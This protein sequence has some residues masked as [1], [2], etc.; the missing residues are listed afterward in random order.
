ME[1]LGGAGGVVGIFEGVAEGFLEAAAVALAEAVD[2]DLDGAFGHVELG[3]ELGVGG[4]FEVG[5]DGGAESFEEVSFSGLDVVG[6][7]GAEGVGEEI[8]GPLAIKGRFGAVVI[9]AGFADE[10]FGLGGIDGDGLPGTAA[11]AGHA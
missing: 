9:Q 3:G 1:F 2:G 6:L 10:L 5:A 8:H 7:R 11:L 4:G